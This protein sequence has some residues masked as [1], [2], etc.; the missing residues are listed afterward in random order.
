M[1]GNFSLDITLVI[2]WNSSKIVI[3]LSMILHSSPSDIKY[4]TFPLIK[5][6]AIAACCSETH[7]SIDNILPHQ[8]GLIC[9]PQVEES[10]VF[11]G[12]DMFLWFLH[13]AIA[14]CIV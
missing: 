12:G 10:F 13:L 14:V 6:A 7:C 3:K 9:A 8:V 11:H 1:V 2:F 4:W 5:I